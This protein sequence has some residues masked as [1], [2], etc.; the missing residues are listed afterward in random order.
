MGDDELFV[1]QKFA[2]H[3]LFQDAVN[4][5]SKKNNFTVVWDNELNNPNRNPRARATCSRFGK[6]RRE[7]P[8]K[9]KEAESAASAKVRASRKK[10]SKKGGCLWQVSASVLSVADEWTVTALHAH[11]TGLCKPSRAQYHVMRLKRGI[12]VSQQVFDDLCKVVC[13]MKPSPSTSQMRSWIQRYAVGMRTDAM[14]IANLKARILLFEVLAYLL[15]YIN[16]L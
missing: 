1:G 6:P 4:T 5:Y 16:L 2:T 13:G 15:C 11:H 3:K 14:S 9:K 7:Q 12:P 8:A 10:T